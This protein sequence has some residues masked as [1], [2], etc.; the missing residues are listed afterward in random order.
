MK[1]EFD[2]FRILLVNVH[3]AKNNKNYSSNKMFVGKSDLGQSQ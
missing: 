1:F 3:F 2:P